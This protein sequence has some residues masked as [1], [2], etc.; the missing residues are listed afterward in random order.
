ML[1]MILVS[2]GILSFVI[3]K[4]NSGNI[5][6]APNTN[7][8]KVLPVQKN[9]NEPEF[10][11]D[12]K[13][14]KLELERWNIFNDG[15]HPEETT[16]GMN[17]ALLWAQENSYTTFY[18]PAGT[19]M[20]PKGKE[21]NDQD[22]RIKMVSNMTF[23]LDDEAVIQKETNG[24]EIYSTIF[25]DSDVE[26][27]TIKGGT[28]RGD[29]ETHDF[30]HQGDESK[31][32]AGTHEWGNGIDTAGAQN[33]LIEDMK[34]E[35]FSGD[36]I[37]IG[38]AVIYGE[39]ITEEH[40]E[41]GGID[42]NGE[43]VDQKG[44]VRSN[45]YDV[46]NF[47]N[48][49]YDNPHYRNIMMWIP[50]GVEGN[51]DIFFY[52]KDDSFIR[53]DKDMH[54]NSTWGYSKV[55]DDADYFRVVFNSDTPKDVKVNRM[56]VAITKNMTI[57]NCDIGYNRRQ[58]I[59]VGA[60][61]GIEI[62]NNKIHHTEGIAPESGIDIE[63]GFYPAINTL[64]K[65]NQ[66]LDNK[67]HMVFAYGGEAVIEENYFGPNKKNG[68]GFHINPAYYGAVIRNNEFDHSDFTAWGHIEFIGNKLTSSSAG[69]E[70]GS[71]VVVDKVKGTDSSLSFKQTEKAGIKVSNI[72]LKSSKQ[73]D[74]GGMFIEGMP[75]HMNNIELHGNNVISGDGNNNNVYDD[76]SFN[77]TPE[78][79]L[80]RGTYSN[81]TAN[82]G[83]FS[84]NIP[85]KVAFNKCNFTNTTFYTYNIEAEAA[86]QNSTFESDESIDY[87]IILALEA[88]NLS[89]LDSTFN[90]GFKGRDEGH[91][92]IQLG[93]DA[94]E[95]NDTKVFGA[96]LKG[97]TIVTKVP[98]NGIDTINGGV[99]APPYKIENNILY[100]AKL[101][102]T[103]NDINRKNK[104]K[105]K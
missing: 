70:G 73:A 96:T 32:T 102:L 9:M 84:I 5:D 18:V 43:P 1:L 63:S 4:G 6:S 72:T 64:I 7:E 31:G 35:K 77:N 101:N 71:N 81:C 36:G 49:I 30:S 44:K 103:A 8:A 47:N 86:F 52:R 65:G 27:V 13:V 60:S 38:G 91:T 10:S 83:E 58:G 42:D 79:N 54:F 74:E 104:L 75:L 14:Y 62:M 12:E 99:G 24:F 37:E 87:Q 98:I 59:T 53:A 68:M 25:L 15:T 50:N 105:D 21:E 82:E 33:I 45:Q 92:V 34:I 61:D 46:Q 16:K 94:S 40:L 56:T 90:Y 48:P 93:R 55:P 11:S 3:I 2:G 22:A 97:N 57:K 51:Y 85:G 89:V 78:M 20:V 76:I 39:Y 23:Y 100:N 95:H 17:E 26:N 88:K 67:I 66:F 19:Y 80:A 69:F 41:L 29:R 28:L